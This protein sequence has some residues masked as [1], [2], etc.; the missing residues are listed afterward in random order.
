MLRDT[1][2]QCAECYRTEKPLKE[3]DLPWINPSLKRLMLRN[4]ENSRSRSRPIKV[5]PSSI[6]NDRMWWRMLETLPHSVPSPLLHFE[7]R[8]PYLD[9]DLV[10][11]LLRIPREQLVRPGRR[12][13]LMR[14][15]MKDIVPFE[16]LERRRKASLIRSPLATLQREETRIRSIFDGSFLSQCDLIDERT[17]LKSLSVINRGSDFKGWS[18]VTRAIAF[19]FWIQA[20]QSNLSN[21]SSVNTADNIWHQQKGAEEIRTDDV[22]L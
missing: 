8:Y 6:M 9:R 21:L 10:D 7:Y 5:K 4:L 12:R 20:N 15:A 3:G 22:A 1:I 16:I 18:A 17:L 14:R 19:E 13:S 2:A 11:F